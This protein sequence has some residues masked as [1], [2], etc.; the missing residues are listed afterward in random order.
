MVNRM[1]NARATTTCKMNREECKPPPLRQ[2]ASESSITDASTLFRCLANSVFH[3]LHALMMG[4][5]PSRSQNPSASPLP[6][7]TIAHAHNNL[8]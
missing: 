1:M 6:L 3:R 2:K 4:R 8:S 7:H 5:L